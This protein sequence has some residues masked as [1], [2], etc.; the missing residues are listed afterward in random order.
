VTFMKHF[1]SGVQA[2]NFR[3]SLVCTI[4]C[5]ILDSDGGGNEDY[6]LPVYWA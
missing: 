5:D 3:E 4:I 6:S 1:K 2:I